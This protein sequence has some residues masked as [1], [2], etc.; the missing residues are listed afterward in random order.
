MRE[1]LGCCDP[2]NRPKN[3]I[4]LMTYYLL[5]ITCCRDF[6]HTNREKSIAKM[7]NKYNFALRKSETLRYTSSQSIINN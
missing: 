5:L 6:L 3:V 1:N 7:V 2:P 4:I